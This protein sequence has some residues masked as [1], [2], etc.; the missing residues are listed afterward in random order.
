MLLART[1][2]AGIPDR[3][4]SYDRGEM[5][6][7]VH[8]RIEPERHPV[9]VE[10]ASGRPRILWGMWWTPREGPMTASPHSGLAQTLL[11]PK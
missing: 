6:Q 9:A 11:W 7:D 3:H 4:V 2:F 5:Y 8:N 10:P 1:R